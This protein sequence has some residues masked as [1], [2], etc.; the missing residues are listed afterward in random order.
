MTHV[1]HE[2]ERCAAPQRRYPGWSRFDQLRRSSMA[3]VAAAQ[4][5]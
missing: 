1:N 5:N 3:E 2:A 4:L